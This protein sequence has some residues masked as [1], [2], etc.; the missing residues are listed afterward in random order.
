LKISDYIE[1]K[2]EKYGYK[3]SLSIKH[4]NGLKQN[5][6]EYNSDNID[7]DEGLLFKS[8][9]FFMMI[10]LFKKRYYFNSNGEPSS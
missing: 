8:I 2:N 10:K 3:E 7:S 1:Q 4:T 5:Q 6:I 9:T